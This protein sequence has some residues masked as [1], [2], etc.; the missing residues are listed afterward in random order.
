MLYITEYTVSI[1]NTYINQGPRIP[2]SEDTCLTLQCDYKILQPTN[3][4]RAMSGIMYRQQSHAPYLNIN[5]SG[6]G[7]KPSI[8]SYIKS[9]KVYFLECISP[10]L[11]LTIPSVNDMRTDPGFTYKTMEVR[12]KIMMDQLEWDF[13]YPT[14]K[15]TLEATYYLYYPKLYCF[16]NNPS[17]NSDNLGNFNWSIEFVSSS[18]FTQY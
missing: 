2:I 17:T 9:N 8:L 10:M 7:W 1:T 18:I 4:P 3:S 5:L 15:P 6:S 16:A 11:S 12:D 14:V 13:Y